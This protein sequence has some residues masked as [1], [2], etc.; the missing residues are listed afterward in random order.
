M[1]FFLTH[2]YHLKV[3]NLINQPGALAGN[4]L[5]DIRYLLLQ[6]RETTHFNVQ[7]FDKDYDTWGQ[8]RIEAYQIINNNKIN[9]GYAAHLFLDVLWG[10]HISPLYNNKLRIISST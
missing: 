4:L 3:N 6:K 5:P 10:K 9:I 7:L 2:I 1:P 8:F